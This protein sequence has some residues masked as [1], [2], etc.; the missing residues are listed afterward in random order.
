LVQ[1][2]TIKA[3]MV[4]RMRIAVE[5]IAA[6][7]G[8]PP[9]TQVFTND[10]IRAR[11]LRERVA[12]LSNLEALISRVGELEQEKA[13]AEKQVESVRGEMANLQRQKTEALRESA[14]AR[15]ILATFDQ[16]KAEAEQQLEN[17]RRAIAALQEEARQ[18]NT[19]LQAARIALETRPPTP[20]ATSIAR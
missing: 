6:E 1:P 18:L 3:E 5:Q 10:A 4:G 16:R 2:L 14:Q 7:Y 17:S 20:S 11:M 9:F 8:N 12:L 19:R 13:H 15:Q